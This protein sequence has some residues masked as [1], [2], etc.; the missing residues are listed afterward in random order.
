VGSKYLLV[1]HDQE[2]FPYLLFGFKHGGIIR[3][4]LVYPWS[5]NN[6]T[7]LVCLNKHIE[8][9]YQEQMTLEDLADILQGE[10]SSK[11]YAGDSCASLTNTLKGKCDYLTIS[12]DLSVYD[13]EIDHKRH[14]IEVNVTKQSK[15]KSLEYLDYPEYKIKVSHYDYVDKAGFY[16]FFVSY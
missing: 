12:S 4:T 15:V 16:Y 11:T 13:Y 5:Q 9:I 3:K 10:L 8:N 6:L 1:I 2:I 14:Q 7:M